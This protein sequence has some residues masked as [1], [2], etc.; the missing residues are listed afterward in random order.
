MQCA[1]KKNP[2][3]LHLHFPTSLLPETRPHE[4]VICIAGLD[5]PMPHGFRP[6]LG[7]KVKHR[8][9]GCGHRASSCSH[10]V[11]KPPVHPGSMLL[12]AGGRV[13][14]GSKVVPV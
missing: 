7:G 9:C 13:S 1:G 11:E 5:M 14:I 10:L 8:N 3:D 12:R 2:N 6:G 4:G